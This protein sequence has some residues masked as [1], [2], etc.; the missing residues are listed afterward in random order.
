MYIV[1][2]ILNCKP[3]KVRQMVENFQAISAAL[4]ELGRQPLRLMTEV[5]GEP[6]WTLVVEMTVAT[7]DELFETEQTVMANESIRTKMA[8]YHELVQSGRRELYRLEG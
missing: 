4:R 2:Q 6:F 7:V 3:G 1:R 5:S 8:G